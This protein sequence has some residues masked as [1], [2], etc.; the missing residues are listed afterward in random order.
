MF[1]RNVSGLRSVR[2][3]NTNARSVHTHSCENLK[4]DKWIMSEPKILNMSVLIFDFVVRVPY[5]QTT[6]NE[7]SV[8]AK[9]LVRPTEV[10]MLTQV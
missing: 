10:F 1:L 7:S 8:A 4:F 2:R 6:A 5:V 3:Y 9:K